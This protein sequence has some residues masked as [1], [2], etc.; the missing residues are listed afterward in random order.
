MSILLTEVSS[1]WED[2]HD[3]KGSDGGKE[4]GQL[5]IAHGQDGSNEEGL[6]TKLWNLRWNLKIAI[7]RQYEIISEYNSIRLNRYFALCRH[8]KINVFE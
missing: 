4:D 8:E 5:V 6:V 7:G 1:H 2:G 3:T